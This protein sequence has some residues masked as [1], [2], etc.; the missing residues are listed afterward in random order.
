MSKHD[1]NSWNRE[2][3]NLNKILGKIGAAGKL[4]IKLGMQIWFQHAT[5]KASLHF[6]WS[7]F[8]QVLSL[9]KAAKFIS[10]TDV[11]EEIGRSKAIY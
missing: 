9:T 2:I 6:F 8:W 3:Y 7:N 1:Y 11:N 10:L 5:G 4:G